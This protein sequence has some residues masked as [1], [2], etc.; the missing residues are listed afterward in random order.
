MVAGVAPAPIGPPRSDAVSA[1]N[2]ERPD[3]RGRRVHFPGDYPSAESASQRPGPTSFSW[4]TPHTPAGA[5]S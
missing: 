2:A 4:P 5:A 3:G 1:W